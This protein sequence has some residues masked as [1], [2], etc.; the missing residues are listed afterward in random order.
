MAH[1]SIYD[2]VCELTLKE[3][4]RRINLHLFRDCHATFVALDDPLHVHAIPRQLGHND[5]RTCERYY[6]QATMVDAARQ[7]QKGIVEARRELLSKGERQRRQGRKG[8]N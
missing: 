6:N 5:F 3:F 2:T 7:Y 4:G 8:A 1:G